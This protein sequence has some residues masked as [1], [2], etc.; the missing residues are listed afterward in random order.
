MSFYGDRVLPHVINV[1]MNTKQT[2]EIRRRVCADLAGDVVEIGF[3]TGHNLPFL[4]P[5]VQ[6][7]RAVEPGLHGRGLH[8]V[9]TFR[10]G[11]EILFDEATHFR[12]I[13]VARDGEGG[14]VWRVVVTEEI[15]DVFARS[16]RQIV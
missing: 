7:L 16:L 1:V 10:D 3:G 9:G 5:T 6:S 15:A 2:R 11:P 4:P 12:R 14:I 8:H 13:E